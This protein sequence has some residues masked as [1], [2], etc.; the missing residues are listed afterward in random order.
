MRRRRSLAASLA[1]LVLACSPTPTGSPSPG[2]DSPSSEPSPSAA[3]VGPSAQPSDSTSSSPM[4][5]AV[6]SEATSSPA[7]TPIPL[8]ALS[9][10][11]EELT[12]WLREDVRVDCRPRRTDLPDDALIGAECFPNHDLVA[13][14]GIYGF[15]NPHAAAAAYVERMSSAGVELTTGMCVE[16]IPGDEAWGFEAG[17]ADPLDAIIVDGQVVSLD[18][19]GCFHDE[20]GTANWRATC[21]PGPTDGVY[22]GALGRTSDIGALARWAWDYPADIEAETFGPPGICPHEPGLGD[23]EVPLA[24]GDTP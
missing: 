10:R 18:R 6:P 24:P 8:P 5:T 17:Y 3:L 7:A 9:P 21:W 14:V 23:P 15:D 4:V 1:I 13:R 19:A 22:V 11:E 2:T 16:G 20:D 12:H